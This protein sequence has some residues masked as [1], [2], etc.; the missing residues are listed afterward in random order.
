MARRRRRR[1]LPFA[2]QL[3]L[4][5]DYS[6]S[7]PAVR[8]RSLSRST[9]KRAPRPRGR[10]ATSSTKLEQRGIE[11]ASYQKDNVAKLIGQGQTFL[12]T[13]ALSDIM[14]KV[15]LKGWPYRVSAFPSL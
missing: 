9:E 11:Q 15:S 10:F 3:S 4:P 2:G 12:L 14:S 8:V 13:P 7:E 6:R 5:L 1:C